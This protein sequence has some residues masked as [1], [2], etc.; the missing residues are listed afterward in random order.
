M[1]SIFDYKFDHSVLLP[2]STERD[3]Q[4]LMEHR[5]SGRS[6]FL[7]S[8]VGGR[9]WAIKRTSTTYTLCYDDAVKENVEQ[10]LLVFLLSH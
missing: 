5:V 1:P 8:M 6:Y 7:N 2:Q 3:I 4:Y 10:L 9:G